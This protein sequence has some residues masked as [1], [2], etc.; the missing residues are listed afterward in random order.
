M[1]LLRRLKVWWDSLLSI[2]EYPGE[3]DVQRG[4]RRIVVAYMVIGIPPRLFFGIGYFSE[5]QPALA[6]VEV[7]AALIPFFGLLVLSVR[8]AWYAWIVNLLLLGILLENLAATII[9]GGLFPSGMLVAFGFVVVVGALIALDSKAGL[10][11]F[12]AYILMIVAAVVLP[13]RIEPIYEVESSQADTASTLIATAIFLYAGMAYFV[14]QRDRFQRESDELLHNI[15]PDEIAARLK[16]EKTMIA[17][18]Y[19]TS[20][21][22]FA[23]VVGFTPMSADMSPAEL[24]GLLNTVFSAF[25]GFVADLGLEKIKTVGD[26]YMVASGVPHPR[27]DHADAIATLALRIRDH[28]QNHEFAGHKISLRIGINSGP[29][30]AGIV[31]TDKF[32]YDLWGDVVNTASRMESEGVPGTIQITSATHELIKSEFVCEP[33]G[34][35]QIKGKGE[36]N[37]YFLISANSE[38]ATNSIE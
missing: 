23:D 5:G 6:W 4:K 35:V 9:V 24:V 27:S 17:D 13:E 34:A 16:S 3:R 2:G 19:E 21:V 30:V 37:T 20:S 18:D 29:V 25:D 10:W 32:S 8:P 12:L 26:E 15:L 1:G 33:R 28:A 7:L 11:W 38:H 36:M 31:G 14:R 22:L